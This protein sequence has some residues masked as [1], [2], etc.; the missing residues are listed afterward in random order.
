M[1]FLQNLFKGKNPVNTNLTIIKCSTC[2]F[3][4]Q[5]NTKFCASCGSKLA[6]LPDCF[7]AFISYRRETASELASLIKVQ[8]ENF[9][10]KKIFLDVKELQVG[11]FDEALLTRIEESPNFILILSKNSLDRCVEKS[12][13]LKREIIHALA[14]DRNIIPVYMDGFKFPEQDVWTLL[15]DK[16]KNLKS[17]QAVMY[18]HINQDSAIRQIASYMKVDKS[19]Q[20]NK[21]SKSLADKKTNHSETSNNTKSELD[22]FDS[23][24][25]R[26]IDYINLKSNELNSLKD[27]H[28]KEEKELKL[29]FEENSSRYV[30]EG[31]LLFGKQVNEIKNE[32]FKIHHLLSDYK[33][34]NH[35][36]A[37]VIC[38]YYLNLSLYDYDK[39]AQ[40]AWLRSNINCYELLS[41]ELSVF[42][43]SFVKKEIL[44][45]T[46]IRNEYPDFFSSQSVLSYKSN[47]FVNAEP[48]LSAIEISEYFTEHQKK[49]RSIASTEDLFFA[50]KTLISNDTSSATFI[51]KLH[52]VF[53]DYMNEK[54]AFEKT[55][56]RYFL[57]NGYKE[58]EVDKAKME[59]YFL[60]CKF[61]YMYSYV[62]LLHQQRIEYVRDFLDI[63]NKY[64]D[65]HRNRN[66][67]H[68]Y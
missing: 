23:N 56:V 20:L 37:F 48:E 1:K 58:P 9:Y 30:K 12:D 49:I 13:W 4:N 11:K 14:T 57:K 64:I 40:K 65:C 7:D 10:N 43:E 16:M 31:I 55:V 52:P 34:K 54:I 21:D 45:W 17:L 19:Q 29:N 2:G 60:F 22:G 42:Q 47:S 62:L 66:K 26:L 27:K 8:L 44:T 53:S 5:S 28:N 24:E 35:V 68:P 33:P 36:E 50:D 61:L 63:Q 59:F 18:N 32:F 25:L 67:S 39:T 51:E 3:N 46:I 38:D 41:K 15:P 6:E